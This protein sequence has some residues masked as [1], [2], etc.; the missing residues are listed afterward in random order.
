[1]G[2]LF[3]I[4]FIVFCFHVL[5]LFWVLSVLTSVSCLRFCS[6][7]PQSW[8]S[9]Y[10]FSSDI[11]YLGV[12]LSKFLIDDCWRCHDPVILPRLSEDPGV[13]Y[14]GFQSVSVPLKPWETFNLSR[15]VLNAVA[16][17]ACRSR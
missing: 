6:D 13:L 16:P 17:I 3:F 15:T 14:L 4:L 11:L 12:R 10:S 7:I 8:F 2:L 5:C 9:V 1:M